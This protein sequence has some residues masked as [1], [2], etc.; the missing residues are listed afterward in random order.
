M[1]RK[2]VKGESLAV[3]VVA[4]NRRALAKAITLLEDKRPEE[5]KNAAALLAELLPHTGKS[6]RIGISGPPGVGK[7]TFIEAFGQRLLA[8]G[9]R[10]AVLAVDPSSPVSGGS[11]LGDRVRM[12]TLSSHQDVFIRPSPAGGTLGGVARHSREAILACEAA[13]YDVLLIETVG[14]GQSETVVASMVDV[15]LMLAMPNAGDEIQGIKRGILELADLVAVTKADG[16]LLPD[17]KRTQMELEQALMMAK[18]DGTLPPVLLVSSISGAGLE[19]LEKALGD[20]VTK[21]N[22]SGDF[23]EN[24][25]RQAAAWFH[26]EIANELTARLAADGGTSA[27]VRT[28]EIEVKAGRIPAAVAATRVVDSLLQSEK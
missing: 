15:F 17:A 23:K 26:Q 24:R 14:V 22:E 18:S 27:L 8:K 9:Q 28:L 21:R 16:T 2:T 12:E 3:G 20:F 10:L 19:A 1:T 4:G 6:L 25:Q 7:S 5:R 11:I 13:G